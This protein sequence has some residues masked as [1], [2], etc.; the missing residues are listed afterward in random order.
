MECFRFFFAEFLTFLINY[1]QIQRSCTLCSASRFW[2]CLV[3]ALQNLIDVIQNC[4]IDLALCTIV[5][6]HT[7]VF[8]YIY[9]AHFHFSLSIFKYTLI[10]IIKC[11]NKFVIYFSILVSEFSVVHMAANGL[12]FIVYQKDLQ[13]NNHMD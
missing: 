11:V 8:M 3:K 5:Q 10:F 7:K 4:D 9:S 12:L 13:H 1:K 6:S 2:F